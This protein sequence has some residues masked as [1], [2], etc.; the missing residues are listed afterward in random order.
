VPTRRLPSDPSLEQLRSQAKDLQRRAREGDADAVSLVLE[1]HPRPERLAGL[2]RAD[3]QLVLARMYGFPSWP[4][5]RRHVETVSRYARSPHR[6]APGAGEDAADRFLR[7]ACLTYGGDGPERR[8]Q[9][10]ALLAER[11]ELARASIHTAAAVGD[12]AAAGD[13]LGRDPSL[14]RRPGGPHDWEPLLYAAYSRLDSEEAGHSTLEVARLL[15]EHGA[16]PNA[17]FLWEGLSPPFTAL[18]GAF[19]Y[20]EDAPNQPPHQYELELARLLLEAGADAND[21][22]ALYNNHWR[23]TNEH[24]ELLFAHGLGQGDGGPWHRRLAPM[25]ATP[26]QMLEDQLLFAAE[27]G[28]AERVE[29]LLRHGVDADGLGTRHPILHGQNACALAVRNGNG[30]VAELLAAAGATAP[31][32][33]PVDELL[34]ACM[35]GDEPRCR[36][37]LDADPGLAAAA[38]GREPGQLRLAAELGRLD[39]I[40]LLAGL[41]FD[42][43]D[44]REDATALHLAAFT[45][46]RELV[47]LL[48]SLG[49]DP[50][51]RDRSFDATPAGWARHAQHREL[52][53]YLDAVEAGRTGAR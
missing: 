15:L 31:Q 26:A 36:E 17:G 53:G 5:L 50:T 20:G 30:R 18:T 44:P 48:L 9:A 24:L 35:R 40:G 52:A 42:V 38:A 33:D 25:H 32:L 22:Q 2:Q 6:E 28:K 46:N 8:Q 12:A 51:L 49:A 16:D 47:D 41:G 10:R 14:A 27:S 11:P 13:L 34:A 4:R 1:L 21:E 3:A 43:N 29:L 23:A 45:G 7:L 19:G 39:A 37:L